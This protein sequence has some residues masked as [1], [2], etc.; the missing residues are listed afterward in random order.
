MKIDEQDFVQYLT[1]KKHLEPK[2]VDT[3]RIRFLV[4]QRW[5]V[6]NQTDL[7]KYSFEKFLFELKQKGLSNS[8]VNTYIQATK[9]LDG[10]CKDRGLPAG[11]TEG[12]ENLPKTHSEINILSIDEI[13][14]LINTSLDY[15]NRNGVDCAEL[16]R[17]Y[18]AF[19]HFLAVTGSRFEEAASLKIKRLDIDNGR[20]TLVNTKNKDNR[21]IYFEGPVKDELKFLIKDRSSEELVFT[22]SRG[23]NIKAGDYNDDL[24]LR[25]KKAGIT[26]YVHAH[27]LRHCFATNLVVAGV[28]IAIVATLLGHKDIKTTYEAYVHLADDTLKKSAMRNPLLRKFVQPVEMIR[29]IKDTL[30]SFHIADDQRFEF[31]ILETE[32][33]LDVHFR[34]RTTA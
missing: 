2:S 27:L 5:L 22:N 3:Y 11:F 23:Q 14:L 26:K 9:H 33:S 6:E 19:T 24:R 21:F 8:T 15:K 1:I 17:K 34:A 16:D 7:N 4:V 29:M 31:Q 32:G 12:I 30:E 20:A 18:R 25:A 28:D 10:F 13:N